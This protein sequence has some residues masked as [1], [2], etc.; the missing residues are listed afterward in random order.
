MLQVKTSLFDLRGVDDVRL[1][2]GT[3]Q[4]AIISGIKV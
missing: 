1:Q 2:Q 3:L 4:T